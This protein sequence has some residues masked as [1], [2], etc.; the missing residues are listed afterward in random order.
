M[1]A[2][3]GKVIDLSSSLSDIWKVL[4]DDEREVLRKNARIA[5]FKK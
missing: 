3:K 2:K 5:N 4:S 1:S